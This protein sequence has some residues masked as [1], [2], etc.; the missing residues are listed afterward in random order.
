MAN[1]L[2]CDRADLI[3]AVAPVS[4]TLGSAVGCAPSRPVAVLQTHGTADPVVPFNGGLMTGRGGIS[5]I[6]AAPALAARWREINGCPGAPVEVVLPGEVHRFTSAGCAAG[7]DV[8]FM[9]V[10]GGGHTWPSGLFSL[11]E[12]AVGPATAAVNA[13]EASALFFDANGR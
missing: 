7:T 10:D 6:V 5:D 1:R 12:A 9:R 2:A 4:G 11:P 3:A 8:V 13:S